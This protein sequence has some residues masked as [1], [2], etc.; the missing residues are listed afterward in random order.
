MNINL[1]KPAG[2]SAVKL[3]IDS[4]K[5]QLPLLVLSPEGGSKDAPGV[6]WIHGGGYITGMK[7]MVYMSRAIDSVSVPKLRGKGTGKHPL[8]AVIRHRAASGGPLQEEWSV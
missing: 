8:I 3:K 4:G 6:L 5:Y 7:E 2:V 1:R